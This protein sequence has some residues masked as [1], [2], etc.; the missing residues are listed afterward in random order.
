MFESRNL[1]PAVRYLNNHIHMTIKL[2]GVRGGVALSRYQ[3]ALALA[4]ASTKY[5]RPIA[6]PAILPLA[7][8]NCIPK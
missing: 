6:M 3:F 1:D 2:I 7:R 8:P 5:P 4:N